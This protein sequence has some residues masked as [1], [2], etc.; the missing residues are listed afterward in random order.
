ML[1]PQHAAAGAVADRVEDDHVPV[2]AHDVREQAPGD[3]VGRGAERG[4]EGGRDPGSIPGAAR[5]DQT[6]ASTRKFARK[7]TL[8]TTCVARG[9]RTARRSSRTRGT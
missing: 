4:V 9:G 1:Q 2:L 3:D 8:T 6:S 7:A 5:V